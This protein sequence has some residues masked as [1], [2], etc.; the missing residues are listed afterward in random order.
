MCTRYISPDAAA[1]E[2]HWHVGRD[3]AWRGADL[4]PRSPGAFIERHVIRANPSA[5]W[6]SG[7]G[8][9]PGA[10]SAGAVVLG[11]QLFDAQRGPITS[12]STATTIR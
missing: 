5:N 3:N 11:A 12:R 2:R 7:S 9:G 10:T 8:G 1:I 4:F 6:W